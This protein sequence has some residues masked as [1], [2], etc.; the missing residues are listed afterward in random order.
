MTTPNFINIIF[1]WPLLALLVA[2]Y[3]GLIFL[4]VPYALGFSIVVLTV[5][6]R[7]VM[8]PL[9][10]T[11]IKTSKKMQS[12][13]PHI[14]KV[15]EKH[16]GDAKRIQQE[17]MALY[18]EHGIN[19]MAG[20]LPSILQIVILVFG[21]YPLFQNIV[22]HNPSEIMNQVN[23]ILHSMNLDMLRLAK[24]WDTLFFGIPLGKSPADLLKTMGYFAFVPVLITGILQ[25]IQSKMLIPK[26]SEKPVKKPGAE[27]DFASAFQTQ[28]L[29]IFPLMIAYFS[30]TFPIGLAL[31]WNTF[32]LFGIL[33]QYQIQGLGGLSDLVEKIAP[34]K[35]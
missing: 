16:K 28:S 8:A 19:P 5:V 13:T 34:K 22:S 24:P 12:I 14:A 15:K 31:Y 2:I 9:S 23:T 26:A 3:Q 1:I 33:Q 29:Y 20:C 25:F 11:Q 10:A 7:L 27:E 17:T 4:H 32:T 6:I 21:L 35:K 30:Y 18:K